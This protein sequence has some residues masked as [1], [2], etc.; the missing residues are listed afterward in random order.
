VHLRLLVCFRGLSWQVAHRDAAVIAD[1]PRAVSTRRVVNCQPTRFPLVRVPAR[2]R[3]ARGCV[4]ASQHGS[5]VRSRYAGPVPRE[6]WRPL[7]STGP[8]IRSTS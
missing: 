8:L 5:H 4:S 2:V 3:C 7:S 6:R 1:H